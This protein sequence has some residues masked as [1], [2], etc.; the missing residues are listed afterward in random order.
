[1]S[2]EWQ[3]GQVPVEAIGDQSRGGGGMCLPVPSLCV[4]YG[5]KGRIYTY[6]RLLQNI[7]CN[8]LGQ[9]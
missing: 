7:N 1:M 5:N 8:A 2:G 6:M 4:T 9:T 3:V